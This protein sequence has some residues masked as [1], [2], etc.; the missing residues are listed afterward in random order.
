M[1]RTPITREVAIPF[2]DVLH[3]AATPLSSFEL[4]SPVAL[5]D[6][7]ISKL[8]LEGTCSFVP[9][10]TPCEL[11]LTR[12]PDATVLHPPLEHL[13]NDAVALRGL[14]RVQ[15]S[16]FKILQDKPGATDNDR[17]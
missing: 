14:M 7:A 16:S 17:I 11:L 2:G 1:T 6:K 3:L 9:D 4:T 15:G 10:N 12:K 8:T 13:A 5:L